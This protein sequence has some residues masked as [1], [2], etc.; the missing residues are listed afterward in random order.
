MLDRDKSRGLKRP[1]VRCEPGVSGRAWRKNSV[2]DRASVNRDD[3]A[4]VWRI[5][6][7]C[8][9]EMS[10]A[11]G[12]SQGIPVARVSVLLGVVPKGNVLYYL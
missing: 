10:N 9:R 6:I 4:T 8:V 2:E 11:C 3:V 1:C 12:T 7:S 5:V